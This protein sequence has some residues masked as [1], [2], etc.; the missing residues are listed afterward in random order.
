MQASK[1]GI[2]TFN[3]NRNKISQSKHFELLSLFHVL[4]E[5]LI[6][7]MYKPTQLGKPL[8][9]AEYWYA[10]VLYH[11]KRITVISCFPNHS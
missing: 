2:K 4:E 3:K 8:V 1:I 7:V 6:V 9:G 5:F 10:I 11:V